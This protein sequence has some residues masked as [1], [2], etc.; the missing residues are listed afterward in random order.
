MFGLA[1]EFH[2]TRNLPLESTDC[3]PRNLWILIVPITL[4]KNSK[5]PSNLTSWWFPFFKPLPGEMIQVHSY[6]SDGW[7]PRNSKSPS[8][9]DLLSPHSLLVLGSCN[10]DIICSTTPDPPTNSF[11]HPPL[12][13]E[14]MDLAKLMFSFWKIDFSWRYKK[15]QYFSERAQKSNCGWNPL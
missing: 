12:K 11:I 1:I 8:K 13:K 4:S 3:K 6:L 15:G 10:T 14:R 2:S 9:F 7:K 5:S